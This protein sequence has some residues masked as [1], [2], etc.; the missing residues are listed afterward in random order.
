[1]VNCLTRLRH[2]HT[3]QRETVLTFLTLEATAGS[4][5]SGGRLLHLGKRG[6]LPLPEI[7]AT[8][9]LLR[10]IW[11]F[12]DLTA[13]AGGSRQRLAGPRSFLV[14]PL[15]RATDTI[16]CEGCRVRRRARRQHPTIREQPLGP[17]GG[18]GDESTKVHRQQQRRSTDPENNP[19]SPVC[20]LSA[21]Q[22]R[23]L[24]L[25]R[26]TFSACIQHYFIATTRHPLI[27]S[28]H[29]HSATTSA[30]HFS[31]PDPRPHHERLTARTRPRSQ[32]QPTEN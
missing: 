29:V 10:R 32:P 11:V 26:S 5:P 23:P 9:L 1:V 3:R 19:T 4:T 20:N 25:F 16:F 6:A 2:H 12:A 17:L 15:R 22:R 18:G 27:S 8:E 7:E 14:C 24:R 31:S 30:T 28:L 21:S 13:V